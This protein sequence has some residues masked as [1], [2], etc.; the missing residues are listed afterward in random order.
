M[1]LTPQQQAANIAQNV[2][3]WYGA[4]YAPKA[5]SKSAL[6][7]WAVAGP[8][9]PA[10]PSYDV[11]N[12]PVFNNIKAQGEKQWGDTNARINWDVKNSLDD[13][14]AD[15][16]GNIDYAN[17]DVNNPYSKAALLQRNFSQQQARDTNS[18]AAQGQQRTGAMFRQRANTQF[19]NAA[20]RDEL[21][22]TLTRLLG[23]ATLRRSEADTA[24]DSTWGAGH[25][26]SIQNA[27][28]PY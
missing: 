9:K 12:N 17:I 3:D 19:Q 13:I 11:F 6:D 7:Y 25:L 4:A 24:R 10:A 22:K 21:Q 28:A 8:P 16:N 15:A 18:Y 1:A 26:A 20:G 27:P 23:E 2:K 14:G 5:P